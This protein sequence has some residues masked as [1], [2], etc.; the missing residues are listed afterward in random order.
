M[1]V[2]VGFVAL[3]LAWPH[4]VLSGPA[5]SFLLFLYASSSF[6][7]LT[8]VLSFFFFTSKRLRTMPED[9]LQKSQM[10]KHL[11]CAR[12]SRLWSPSYR[13]TKKRVGVHRSIA[14]G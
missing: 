13:L 12:Q 9:T 5:S 3:S 7:F 6:F 11:Q 4:S 8:L 10:H 14:V 1:F 2:V